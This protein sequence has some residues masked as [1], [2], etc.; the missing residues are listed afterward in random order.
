MTHRTTLD[1]LEEPKQWEPPSLI[2]IVEDAEL[3][4]QAGDDD[5]TSGFW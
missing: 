4:G 2:V 5:T 3:G 1:H